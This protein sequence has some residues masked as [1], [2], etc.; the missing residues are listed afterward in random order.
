[1]LENLQWLLVM[2][3]F[4]MIFISQIANFYRT[5]REGVLL[6][7]F[8]IIVSVLVVLGWQWGRQGVAQQ[9]YRERLEAMHR[10]YAELRERYDTLV[11]KSAITELEV[12][13]TG[14]TVVVRSEMGELVRMATN[15]NPELEIYVDY[16]VLDG[17]LW[18][19][20][21]FD[22]SMSP[23]QATYIDPSLI[24]IPWSEAREGQHFGKAVYRYMTP[25]RWVVTT[26]G[27]GAL[28]LALRPKG[29]IV[30]LQSQGLSLLEEGW[31]HSTAEVFEDISWLDA[32]RWVLSQHPW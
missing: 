6:F 9:I 24:G 15:L 19:R 29:D 25:G 7:L 10:E 5:I 17:R 16:V 11:R 8:V 26:T 21:V 18:I 32:A 27:N 1:M 23:E 20:R 4:T 3:G 13:D 2:N 12:D 22:S 30:P 28:G 14:I 31:E